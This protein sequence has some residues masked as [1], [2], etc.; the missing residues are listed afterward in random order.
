MLK[1]LEYLLKVGQA[2]VKG[3]PPFP[4]L[5]ED[6]RGMPHLSDADCQGASKCGA[7][8][9]ECPTNAIELFTVGDQG[10]ISLDLGALRNPFAI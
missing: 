1:L 7:C 2:T 10:K 3:V 9:S 5:D 4:P 8:V 6:F